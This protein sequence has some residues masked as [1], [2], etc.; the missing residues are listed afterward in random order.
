MRTKKEQARRN[1]ALPP[2][3]QHLPHPPPQDAASSTGS[4]NP[5]HAPPQLRPQLLTDFPIPV[6]AHTPLAFN[7]TIT[8]PL[9]IRIDDEDR[10]RETPPSTAPRPRTSSESIP[11]NPLETTLPEFPAFRGFQE[12]VEDHDPRGLPVE[13]PRFEDRA[14]STDARPPSD[15]F[16]RGEKLRRGRVSCRAETSMTQLR[17]RWCTSRKRPLSHEL[18]EMLVVTGRYVSPRTAPPHG[19]HDETPPRLLPVPT[20]SRAARREPRP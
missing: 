18:A 5:V 19:F 14:C 4:D 9:S 16:P 6:H 11:E 12:C 8:R 15:V 2:A 3:F 1:P 20:P 17:H 10:I 13:F 7:L